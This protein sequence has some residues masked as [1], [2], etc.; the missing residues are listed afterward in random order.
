MSTRWISIGNDNWF[1]GDSFREE[2][3]MESSFKVGDKASC[4]DID[5]GKIGT[6]IK[7]ELRTPNILPPYYWITLKYDP[8]NFWIEGPEDRFSHFQPTPASE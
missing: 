4:V 5:E 6:V 7:V 2:P 8:L 3:E 1:E